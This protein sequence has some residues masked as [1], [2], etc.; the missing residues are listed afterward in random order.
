MNKSRFIVLGLILYGQLLVAQDV[1]VNSYARSSL[2]SATAGKLARVSDTLRGLWMAQGAQWFSLQGGVVN[3]RDFGATGD[4]T[5][6]D[7]T[8][9]NAAISIATSSNSSPLVSYPTLYFP[10]GTYYVDDSLAFSGASPL[11]ILGDGFSTMIVNHATTGK[12]T[13]KLTDKMYFIIEKLAILGVSG[14]QNDAILLTRGAGNGTAFGFIRDVM[15]LP[16]GNGIHIVDS[17]TLWLEN[18]GYWPSDSS[19]F[20]ASV[21]SGTRKYGI[22][23]DGNY[24]NE[25]HIDGF[26]GVGADTSI[27]GY[28]AIEW[29]S[30]F[31]LGVTITRSELEG[32][33][34]HA[35][36]IHSVYDFTIADN[37]VEGGY[38]TIT[39][40]RYGVIRT[41]DMQEG[42]VSIT[43]RDAITLTSCV[44]VIVMNSDGGRM[45][46]DANSSRSGARDS[47]FGRAYSNNGANPV[48][49]NVSVAGTLITALARQLT[50]SSSWAPGT[51]ADGQASSTSMTLAG[52]AP[53][54][55]CMAGLTTATTA[56]L[57]ITCV[58]TSANSVAVTLLNK[59]GGSVTVSS[60]TLR[61]GVWK[62]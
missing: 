31:S 40:S 53:G 56:G 25:V 7:T 49:D 33:D 2:P 26:N 21:D 29:N 50:D 12:P 34:Y 8:A 52:A 22:F 11:H 28:A 57:I 17:N 59:T 60:G 16:N 37:T 1:T 42:D 13:F 32:Q 41:L 14:K 36:D 61:V 51:V 18:I 20:G 44:D 3:V 24:A 5:T 47:N 55:P 58:P 30:T 23:A 6:N 38:I 62:Y 48:T 43:T 27:S 10:A 15:L 19:F 46:V 45:T 35:I 39:S 9:I 4:G 54:D